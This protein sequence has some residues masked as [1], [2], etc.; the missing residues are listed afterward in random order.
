M[1]RVVSV[2]RKVTSSLKYSENFLISLTGAKMAETPA[3]LLPYTA[4][5]DWKVQ[6]KKKTNRILCDRNI[7]F[8]T[9]SSFFNVFP[10]RVS[11]SC[12]A[13]IKPPVWVDRGRVSVVIKLTAR[14]HTRG[15]TKSH[16]QFQLTSW[17]FLTRLLSR[18]CFISIHS[19]NQIIDD[20]WMSVWTYKRS[21]SCDVSSR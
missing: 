20:F 17:W 1:R 7:F 2:R 11:P 6:K 3:A 21:A 10:S 5:T 15:K 18:E 4:G 14:P 19:F 8:L 16:T 9:T 13:D 12:S